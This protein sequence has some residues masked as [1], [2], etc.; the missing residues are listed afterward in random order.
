MRNRT[1]TIIG[2]LAV[3]ALLLAQQPVSQGP[4]AS[5][6]APWQTNSAQ[7]AGTATAT[8]SGASN[9]GTQRVILSTDTVLNP[10]PQ[11]SSTYAPSACD[12]SATSATTCKSGAGNVYAWFGFNPNST[13][14]Y[15][16]FYNSASPV[17]GTS[18]LHPFG[19]VAGASFNL[20][21]GSVPLFNMGTAISV[22]ET[23]T[24][25]GSTQCGSPMTITLVY[26]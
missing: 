13:T 22:A 15:L 26:Q 24:P 2:I 14:C 10:T 7:I 12:V 23:T 4:Q 6:A 18:A 9:A 25:T 8:G 16:Q 17:L 19:V 21:P 3:T 11:S 20:V 5:N 1:K